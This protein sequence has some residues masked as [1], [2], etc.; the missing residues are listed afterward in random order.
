EDFVRTDIA[1]ALGQREIGP[2]D[3]VSP[4][5]DVLLPALEAIRYSELRW[6]F[7]NLIACTMDRRTAAR[8][9]P[10]YAD[11]LRQ[12]SRDE[13]AM[14]LAVPPPGRILPLADLQFHLPSREILVAYRNLA[15]RSLADAC[16][17][18]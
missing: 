15:P 11:V 4:R 5:P 3:I 8:V 18:R 16:E 6:A 14:L 1:L 17:C 7:A 10:A 9:L 2:N 13:A 12:L